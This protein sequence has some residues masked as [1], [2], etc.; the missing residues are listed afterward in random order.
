MIFARKN[1]WLHNKTTRSMPGQS[2]NLEAE[3]EAKALRL[4]LLGALKIRK[5]I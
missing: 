5:I 1:A 4:K 2:Q 3:A